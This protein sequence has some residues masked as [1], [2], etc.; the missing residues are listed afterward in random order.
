MDGSRT[1]EAAIRGLYEGLEEIEI[2]KGREMMTSLYWKR[3]MEVTDALNEE[4]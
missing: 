3:T 2:T 4:A 1:T